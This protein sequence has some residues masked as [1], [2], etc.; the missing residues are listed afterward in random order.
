MSME[1]SLFVKH[2]GTKT[3]E[4][5]MLDSTSEVTISVELPRTKESFWRDVLTLP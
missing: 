1:R 3:T 2:A 5:A 4:T